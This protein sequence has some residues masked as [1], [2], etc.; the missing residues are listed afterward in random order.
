MALP[1]V[2]EV[3]TYDLVI[4]SSG[5]T[6]TFRPYLVKEQKVLLMA[7]ESQDEKQVLNSIINTLKSCIY[8]EIAFEDLTTFDVE[9]IFTQI[10]SK[11]VGETSQLKMKCIQCDTPN[12]V[13]VPLDQIKVDIDKNARMIKLN[14]S[15]TLEMKYPKYSAILL[16]PEEKQG[17]SLT[18]AL[19]E[20]AVMCLGYLH[21]EDERINFADE[22]RESIDNF[23][24][25]LNSPQFEKIMDFVN[26]VPKITYDLEY[27]CESCGHH[28]KL[29]LQGI[30]DFF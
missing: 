18:E 12:D 11:S 25:G 30:Q 17:D 1:K 13:V 8:E 23:I 6:I 27:D 4:P 14:D 5:Q 19:Y 20:M 16:A 9:F 22:S 3:P 15:F 2:N 7:M 26:N 10:R 28:N 29:V 24:E 21:T